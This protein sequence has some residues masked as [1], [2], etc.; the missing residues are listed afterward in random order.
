MAGLYFLYICL[1]FNEPFSI[2]RRMILIVSALMVELLF[3]GTAFAQK[4]TLRILA[5]GNSFSQDAVE[6]NLHEIGAAD[7]KVLI[8][9]DMYIPGCSLERHFNNA[10]DDEHAYQYCKVGADGNLTRTKEFSLAMAL[11]DESW[12][13]VS[14]QQASHFSG[15]Y[16]T[17]TPYL[18]TLVSYV[19]ERAPKAT[20]LW[21]QTWAYADGSTHG[22]FPSYESSQNVMY[23]AIMSTSKKA[24]DDYGFKI[25]PSGTAIQNVRGTFVGE[26]VTRDGY[27]MNNTIG[28]YTVALTWY[29]AITGRSVIGN[30]YVT[31][32]VDA[33]QAK[34][35]QAAAHAAVAS[36]YNVSDLGISKHKANYDESAIPEYTLPDALKFQDGRFVKTADQWYGKR[37]AELISLFETE[38]FGKAPDPHPGM[39][40]KLLKEVKGAFDGKARL[41]EIAIYFTDKEN[42]YIR[43]LLITP[44]NAEGPVPVFLGINFWGNHAISS[45]EA[46]SQ[47]D[48]A[49]YGRFGIYQEMGRA[50]N[51]RRWPVK[52][53]LERG[54][55]LATFF[56]S[57]VD[58]D[59]DDSFVNG[60]HRLFY[61]SGRLHPLA[62]EWGTVAAWAWGMSRALDYLETDASVDASRVIALG[63][64][65]LGKA[66]LWAGASDPRFA[67][68]VS[69]CSGSGGAALSRRAIGE[70][71]EDLNRSFPHWFCG[72]FRKYNSNESALPFDQHELLALIAP[73]PLCVG[74][75]E[76]DKWADPMGE[77]MSLEEA[78]K[79]YH[80]LGYDGMTQY[81]IRKGGHDILDEDWSYYID[82]ADKH[83]SSKK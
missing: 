48:A 22:S 10:R 65:R 30:G 43:L 39:H 69:N 78:D 77:K 29:E 70:T 81:H 38:M 80:F 4:D 1:L 27:H 41:K 12:D 56:R 35:A 20:L 74:S 31:P 25:I 9:G 62:D 72:N 23:N 68:V 24:C 71:V 11:E 3:A 6:Q 57:D 15:F 46:I 2:M 60:V 7:G 50:F 45:D 75:A 16:D 73:R 64:S 66:A 55:G 19:K 79:I 13:Y 76:D 59:W 14:L 17:Y 52:T 5:I 37:R 49:E 51:E 8:V 47:P 61:P 67:M 63:H 83:L 33:D 18:P 82:F 36:P 34:V 54:Y 28:R 42:Q 21:H 58:P 26:G 40:Y 32:Y 44:E 53:L